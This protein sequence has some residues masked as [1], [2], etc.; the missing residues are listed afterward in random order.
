MLLESRSVSFSYGRRKVLDGVSFAI[1]GGDMMAILG[2]NGSGKTTLMRLLLGFLQPDDGDILIDGRDERGMSER[3]KAKAIAYIP[4]STEMVYP[5]PV[6]DTVLMGRAPS[7]SIF[8]RPGKG[9]EEKAENALSMLGIEHLRNR[10]VN[11][12]SGGERQLV[13]IARAMAQEARIILLDEPTASLDYSNQLLVM[14][15][16]ERLRTSGYAMLFS[17]HN[18]EQALMNATS[19]LVLSESRIAYSGSPEGLMDGSVLES[20]YSRRLCI[21]SIDTGENER[22]ICIPR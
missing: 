17:T 6:I 22:I 9:D 12:L 18:P 2:R 4:Q 20:L 13:M 5:Y 15:T 8:E 11:E 16:M 3:E 1:E 14:E 10:S 7:L 19:V 21:K